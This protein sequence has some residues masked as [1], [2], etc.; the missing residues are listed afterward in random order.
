MG[1]MGRG[2]VL[3]EDLLGKGH[4]A[5][6]EDNVSEVKVGGDRGRRDKV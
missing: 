3:W 2:F 4:V 5:R 1:E 6:L